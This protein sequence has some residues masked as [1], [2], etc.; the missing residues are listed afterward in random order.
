MERC[1]LGITRTKSM[2]KVADIAERVNKLKWQWAATQ[3]EK[4]GWQMDARNTGMVS[5]RM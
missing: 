1:M 2:T 5:Q 4:N 3:S